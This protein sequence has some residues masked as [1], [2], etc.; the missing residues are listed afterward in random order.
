M[1]EE[2]IAIIVMKKIFL[3]LVCCVFFS[4]VHTPSVFAK[5][6]LPQVLESNKTNSG[7]SKIVSKNTKGVTVAVKL[8]NDKNAINATFT[9]LKI[10]KDISY[11]FSYKNTD[12]IEQVAQSS[13]DPKEKEPVARELLFGTC[14]TGNVCRYDTG[15]HDAKF[16]V[17]TTLLNGK[18]VIKTF[19]IKVKK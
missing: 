7:T 15:V 10:A 14:S 19:T 5:R 12:N 11:T 17:T 2:I 4:F 9:N 16:V 13:V 3:L 18:K 1:K 8:R 6:V